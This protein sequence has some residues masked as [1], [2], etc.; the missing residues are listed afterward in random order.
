LLASDAG[1]GF[2]TALGH[3]MAKNK[4]GKSVLN[5][6]PGAQVLPPALIPVGDDLL[7]ASV[8]SEGRLLVFPLSDL[9]ELA[10]GKGNKIIS[11]PSARVKTREEMMT[12]VAVLT[13]ESKLVLHAGKRHLSLKLQ[14]LDHYRGERGR[15][16]SKLPRGLQNV[17]F[18]IAEH[19]SVS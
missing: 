5:L 17:D 2:V 14:E 13:P 8:S 19:P 18:L 4:A 9:P 6:P 15:R 12:A 11:I 16:G 3:L 10:R 1:N 7:V